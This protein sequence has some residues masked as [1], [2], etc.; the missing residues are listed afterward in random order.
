[1]FLFYLRENVKGEIVVMCKEKE[2][3]ELERP[4]DPKV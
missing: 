2:S 4:S 3:G 1:M